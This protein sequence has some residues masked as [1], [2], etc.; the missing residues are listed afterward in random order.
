MITVGTGVGGGIVIDGHA[1]RG[2]TGAAGEI[3]HMLVAIDESVPAA[4]RFP[5]PGSLEALAAGHVLDR[6]AARRPR[7]HP[8]SALGRLLAARGSIA[9]PDAVV[10]ANAGDDVAV[11]CVATLGRRLGIGVANMINTFDPEVVAIG[12]GVSSAGDLLLGP[13]RAAAR[14]Y[15]LPGRGY[16]D[17]DPDRPVRARRRACGAPRCSRAANSKSTTE[18]PDERNADRGNRHRPA[19][20]QHDPHARRWT[21]CRRRLRP[22]RHADGARAARLHALHASHAPQPGRSGLAR[23]A[24]ASCSRADTPRCCSTRCS[25]CAATASSSPTSRA[26]ASSARHAP[27]TPSTAPPP[28]I[29]A[30][31]GPLGQGISMCVGLALAERL[32]A[33][34]FNRRRPRDHRPPHV[35]DRL[36]RRHGGGYQSEAASLA[37]HLGLGRLIA[38]YDDNHISIEGDTELAF[39]EDVGARYEAY[40]WH[41]QHLGEDIAIERLE[42]GG[43]RA[44]AV[45]DRPS[46]IICRTHIAY[47]SPHKQDTAGPTARHSA[48]MRS[49]SPRRPT[50]G[51]PNRPSSSPRRSLAHCRETIPRGE[52][53][54][55]AWQERFDA[56]RAAQPELAGQLEAIFERRAARAA[57]RRSSS[58]DLAQEDRDAQ[59]LTGGHPGRGGG[60]PVAGRRLG[61]PRAVDADADRRRR[62]RRA[63]QLRRAQPAFRH[64][65]ARD[66]RDRQRPRP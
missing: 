32:L 18:K 27:V 20:H 66:G 57:V 5:Q 53:E 47:G 7:R 38:F 60:G 40:G 45:E 13:A 8:D 56:Y 6:L 46:L 49:D 51:R 23:T 59:G 15:V 64:P 11:G 44:I 9:G 26:S 30:T 4:T 63:R 62:R 29:E 16:R 34:R 41:V 3:G 21:R 54:Q 25:T 55:A 50:V 1:F 28:G 65:R 52:R 33:A 31:T 2:A 35:H 48:R 58:F 14:E 10:A 24:T 36:R 43:A 19:L 61:R 37:G 42:S 22:P 39:S 12:G 17:R